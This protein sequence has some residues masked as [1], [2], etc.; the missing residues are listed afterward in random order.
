MR[1]FY[2]LILWA[3]K[4]TIFK[5]ALYLTKYRNWFTDR[6][7]P[8][9]IVSVTQTDWTNRKQSVIS[10]IKIFIRKGKLSKY[11]IH[12]SKLFR[13][14][15]FIPSLFL[16]QHCQQPSDIFPRDNLLHQYNYSH[17]I[18]H[19][20]EWLSDLLLR[21]SIFHL[22]IPQIN[23][24][25]LLYEKDWDLYNWLSSNRKDRIYKSLEGN[26]S[27]NHFCIILFRSLCFVW[28]A[29][30]IFKFVEWLKELEI[31]KTKTSLIFLCN[32]LVL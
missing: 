6:L 8:K 20:N 12:R 21:K 14:N 1:I 2:I 30:L 3:Q 5:Q 18:S 9:Q 15:I 26:Y 29:K 22:M 19:V 24:Y 11:E 10:N 25:H 27:R 13:P 28:M 17:L 7:K 23:Y 16:A 32:L 4:L 31:K